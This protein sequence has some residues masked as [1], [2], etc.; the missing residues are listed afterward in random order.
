MPLIPMAT[1]N[2]FIGKLN[3]IKRA[4]ASRL[5]GVEVLGAKEFRDRMDKK[6]AYLEKTNIAL[7]QSKLYMDDELTKGFQSQV[8]R[9]TG[10]KWRGL[11]KSTLKRWPH[12]IGK[13]ILNDKGTLMRSATRGRLYSSKGV[14]SGSLLYKP[15][16]SLGKTGNKISSAFVHQKG[17]DG[18]GVGAKPTTAR[19]YL[20][21]TDMDKTQINRIFKQWVSEGLKK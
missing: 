21:L 17:S 1:V 20:K 18:G 9:E 2:S 4:D 7:E 13:P 11:K 6:R 8:D 15:S 16:M 3:A 12:R 14:D 19:P 5:V 10:V